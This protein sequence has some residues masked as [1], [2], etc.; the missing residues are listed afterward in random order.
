MDSS[1]PKV[2]S[3]YKPYVILIGLAALMIVDQPLAFCVFL[4]NCL[5]SWSAKKQVVVSCS[6]TKAEYRS[7]AIATVELYWLRMLFKDLTI[8]LPHAPILWCDNVSALALASNPVYHART[9]H[10]EVDYHF[11]R[12][13][14][15][16][17]DIS[18][19]FISTLDQIADIFTKGLSSSRFNILKSK[20]LV[21]FPPISLRG[22]VSEPLPKDY[23]STSKSSSNMTLPGDTVNNSIPK[24]TGLSDNEDSN[25]D[26]EK[27]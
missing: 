7:M 19:K 17:G 22:I 14:V 24:D 23:S 18:V 12:E 1:T 4:G 21:A 27:G 9:K 6:S 16:N 13:K 8:P 2:L 10:I 20:L 26:L 5:I 25:S 15:I 3:N 11:V